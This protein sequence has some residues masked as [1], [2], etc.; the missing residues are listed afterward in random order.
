M[1]LVSVKL[2]RKTK[3][4]NIPFLEISKSKDLPTLSDSFNPPYQETAGK[5]VDNCSKQKPKQTVPA[6]PFLLLVQSTSRNP[7][8]K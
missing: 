5:E 6:S 4:G 8:R 2:L 7:R 3:I 1:V